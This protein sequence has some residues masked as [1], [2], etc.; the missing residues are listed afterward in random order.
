MG[1]T[2]LHYN[3]TITLC[4]FV[5]EQLIGH[6][7]LLKPA[8]SSCNTNILNNFHNLTLSDIKTCNTLILI[9]KF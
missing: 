7:Q 8:H 5:L 1:G 3:V 6:T 4:S 2:G 9:F